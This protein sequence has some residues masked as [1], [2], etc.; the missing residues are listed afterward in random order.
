M[1]DISLLEL[2]V[3]AII[4]LL[5]LGPSEM[6][7]AMRWLGK[8]LYKIRTFASQLWGEIDIMMYK[9]E[10]KEVVRKITEKEQKDKDEPK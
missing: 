8:V 7:I 6:A 2:V 4:F 1:F 9:E 10:Y 5:V 3:I